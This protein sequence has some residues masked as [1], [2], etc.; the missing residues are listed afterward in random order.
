VVYN[1]V[2]DILTIV[3]CNS[4]VLLDPEMII[5]G[6]PCDWNWISLITTIKDRL[7]TALLRPVNIVP[8][9]LGREA[10]IMGGSYCALK[11]QPIFSK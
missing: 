4:A 7:G 11:L 9:K 1:Y 3:I 5:L 8:S 6:G 10:V 2:V